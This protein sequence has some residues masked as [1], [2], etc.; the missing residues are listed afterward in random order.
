MKAFQVSN[1]NDYALIDTQVPVAATGEVLIRTAFAGICGSDLHII[2]GQNPFVEFPRI[3]G[4]E[5]SGVVAAIGEGVEHVAVGDP[6]CVDPVISCGK[7]YACR[8]GRV[9][10]CA[11][12]QVF[13]VHRN[14]GFGEFTSAP[15]SNVLAL[16][17]NVSLEQAALVEPYSIATNVLTRM[18]P[19]PGDTLLVYGAGVIGL[20][21]VQVARAMGIE[22]VIV[23]DIVDERLETAKLLGATDVINS[24]VDNVEECI[25]HWTNGEGIPLIADAACLPALLPE[26]LRIA[27]PAGRVGLLGFNS[28]PSDM[29]QIE[30]IKKELTIVGSRLN[31]RRFPQ[32]LDMIASGRLDPLAL[33][34]HRIALNEISDGIQL[35]ENHPELTRKVLVEMSK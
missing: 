13:G 10:V 4:H 19:L 33:I 30:V 8:V 28:I 21:I 29:A 12:L 22:Q 15:A 2:H 14:G 32:V 5:F 6:V 26:I 17:D 31:N 9:N 16:P 35:M 23:T 3:T 27:C 11:H 25:H 34:S 18:E 1:V 24:R 7:C 20:T